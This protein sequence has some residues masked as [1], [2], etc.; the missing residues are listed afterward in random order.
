MK[1]IDMV[2]QRLA[3]YLADLKTI[4]DKLAFAHEKHKRSADRFGVNANSKEVDHWTNM[5]WDLRQRIEE[6][7]WVLK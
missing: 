2:E 3:G 7:Q 5:A 6:L 1:C 4:E